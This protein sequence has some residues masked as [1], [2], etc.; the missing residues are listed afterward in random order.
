MKIRYYFSQMSLSGICFLISLGCSREISTPEVKL[1]VLNSMERIV[2]DQSIIGSDQASIKAAKNEVESFQVVVAAIQKNIR[3]TGAEISDL[4]GDAGTIAKEN[5]TLFREEYA[6]VRRSSPRAQL[7]PGLYPDPLVPFIN[8][9]TGKPIE[10][11]NEYRKKWGEPF[12]KSGFEMYAIPFDVWKGQNQPIWVDV[13]IP[14][15]TAAGEYKGVLSVT[16]GNVPEQFGIKTDSV[17]TKQ[18]QFQ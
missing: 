3:V 9:R 12:I 11:F 15:G 8:P 16:L 2:P 13:Y 10:P 7:P 17:L 1:T 4:K 18:S 5:V 6:R 14:A